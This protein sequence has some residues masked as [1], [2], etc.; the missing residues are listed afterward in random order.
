MTLPA[1]PVGALL[2]PPQVAPEWMRSVLVASGA[3]PADAR[4]DSVRFDDY[5]GTGQLGRAAR[6]TLQWTGSDGLPTTVV[7]KIPGMQPELTGPLFDSGMY[8][9]EIAFYNHIAHRVDVSLPRCYH[10][11]GDRDELLFM[12]LME[13]LA[14]YQAGDHLSG[15]AISDFHL[16]VEQAAKLHGPTWGDT[17]LV[18][19]DFFQQRAEGRAEQIAEGYRECLPIALERLASGLSADAIDTVERLGADIGTWIGRDVGSRHCVVHGDFRPDNLLLSK[20]NRERPIIVVDWQTMGLGLGATDLAYLIG[21]GMPAEQRQPIED[22]LLREYLGHLHGRYGLTS[23]TED[24]LRDD[25]ALGSLAGL[26]VAITA[27]VR[28]LR[29]ERGDNLFTMMI[30][31][32]AAHAREHGALEAIKG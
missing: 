32:H 25:Y 24:Q 26:V 14:E 13:D 3:V 31:R 16:A 30:E 23:Y 7:A 20:T 4:L 15:I 1:S 21:G 2:D 11:F 5:I 27:T 17:A 8:D 22:D 18:Q 9:A 28:A 19:L 6:F 12:I 10:A 29:T